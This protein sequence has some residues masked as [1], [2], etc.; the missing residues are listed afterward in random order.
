M[1]IL[2][3]HEQMEMKILDHMRKVKIL[4]AL[5][6]GGGTMLRLCFDL[7]RYSVD[8]DFYLKAERKAFLP[9]AKKFTDSL[10]EMGAKIKDHAE[11]YFSFLWEIRIPSYSRHLKIEIRKLSDQAKD[12]QLNIAHS[13]FS[14]LQVR[15][16]TLT[17]K[18]MWLNKIMALSERKEVR[19]AYDLEFLTRRGGGDFKTLTKSRIEKLLQVLNAFSKQELK[20]MG[21]VLEKEERE[22][23]ASNRF[24][25]LKS[26]IEAALSYSTLAE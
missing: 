2:Q 21:S 26:K 15:L 3:Q 17:L 14:S 4:D 24:D 1:H 20:A 18:Q 22:M 10:E 11:K 6:F 23:I 9:Q 25:Y 8:L 13:P 5:I 19:D 12:T 7:P 16:R